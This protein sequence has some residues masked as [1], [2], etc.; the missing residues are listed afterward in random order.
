M[1]IDKLSEKDRFTNLDE[2]RNNE[3]T[4]L[5]FINKP[6]KN[7]SAKSEQLSATK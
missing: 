4:L 5:R 7:L 6:L 3:N 2:A 1:M